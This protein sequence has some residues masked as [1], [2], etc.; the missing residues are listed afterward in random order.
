M[1]TR[2]DERL[3]ALRQAARD[4]AAEGAAKTLTRALDGKNGMLVAVAAQALTPERDGAPQR[5]LVERLPAAFERLR[6]DAVKRDPQ[7]QGKTAIAMCLRE[8]EA[9]ADE[10]F[11]AG[12]RHVQMEPVW[13]G[14]VDT[15][16]QLRGICAMA[17]AEAGHPRAMVEAAHLLADDLAA[18]RTAAARAIGCSANAASGEP[19]LRLRIELGEEEPEVLGECFGALLEL[20]PA[21]SLE[22]VGSYLGSTDDTAMEAAALAL[23][24]S[25]IEDAFE[26]LSQQ[27]ERAVHGGRRDVLLLGLAMLRND[28]A[29]SHLIEIIEDGPPGSAEGAVRALSTFKYDERLVQRVHAA[30]QARSDAKVTA[31][32]EASFEHD[33]E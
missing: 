17:L 16:A 15:A 8:L 4:P 6:E 25:R 23:G 13:G 30:V 19:L 29:W 24:G 28:R 26:P 7:C 5:K 32:F 10:V 1:S 12:A 22:F 31:R 2:F 21:S 9:E 14:R 33:E 20:A 27:A 11:L 18:A 3:A